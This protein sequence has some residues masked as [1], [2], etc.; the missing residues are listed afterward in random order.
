MNDTSGTEALSLQVMSKMTSGCR[1]GIILQDCL[2]MHMKRQEKIISRKFIL[3]LFTMQPSLLGLALSGD[4]KKG[5][6]ESK[7]VQL[8]SKALTEQFCLCN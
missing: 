2:R 1:R 8:P 6:V 4:L 5:R 7:A 3:S